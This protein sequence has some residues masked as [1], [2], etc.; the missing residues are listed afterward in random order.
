MITKRI[1][2]EGEWRTIQKHKHEDG[3]I[4]VEMVHDIKNKFYKMYP[5][6]K[7]TFEESKDG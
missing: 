2:I 7:I 6:N 1:A 5:D 4:R 3:D